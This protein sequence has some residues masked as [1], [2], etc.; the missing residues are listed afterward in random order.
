MSRSSSTPHPQP[1][2]RGF[3]HRTP[4][5]RVPR[6][7]PLVQAIGV[8]LATGAVL[9]NA[10]AQQA[11]S[12]A[13]FAGKGAAQGVAAATGRLP[14]G[15]PASSL[16][17]PVAQQQKAQAELQRSLDNLNLAARGIAA[18]QA[19]QAAARQAALG[20]ASG[21]PDGLGE[22]GL[23][24]DG[25]SLTAGWANANAPVQSVANGRT[26]VAIQQTADKA[27][28]NW[29]TFNV[30]RN[31]TVQFQ[32]DAAWAVLNRVNDPQARPS[33]IQGQI[34]ADGT[35]M[36]VNRNG[37]V[38][39]GSS[40]VDSRNLVAAAAGMS[41]SQFRKGLYG[42]TVGGKVL[43]SFAN[44]LVSSATGFSHGKASGDVIVE[45]GASIQ[46]RP[47]TTV[48][49]GGGY[50]LLAGRETRNGGQI[51]TPGG[52]TVL[53]AG[54]AFA[55]SRGLDSSGN[56]NSSTR[57]NVVTPLL[58]AGSDAGRVANTG[59]IQAT[60]GDITLTGRE[61]LQAGVIQ[62]TSSVTTRGTVH[63]MAQSGNGSGTVT[64]A[65]GS[66]T[67]IGLD[68]SADTA[69][70]AQR[71]ALIALS[72]KLADGIADRR[73]LSLVR[74]AS[75]GEV[76]FQDR[77]L[78]LA[79]GGQVFVDA[80]R[81]STVGA[82][83]SIDVSGAVGVQL[84]MA[85]NNVLVNVQGNEQR[86][87]PGNRDSAL[88][89]NGNIWIDRRR[90]VKVAKGTGGYDADRWYTAGGLLEVGGYLGTSGHGIGEWAA[91]GGTVQFGGGELLTQRG[92]S[93][94]LSGGTLD[95]ATGYLQQTFLKGSDGR[96]Y[97]ASSAP[98]DLLYT[99]IYKGYEAAHARWGASATESFYNP[100]IAPQRRLESGYTV[101][102]DAGRLIVSTGR[103]VLEGGIETVAFQGERQQSARDAGLDSYQQS[104]NAVASRGQ[105]VIGRVTPI[106]DK[107][108]LALRE[109]VL[110]TV[111][112]IVIGSFAAVADALSSDDVLP[113]PVTGGIGIDAGWLR[114][115]QLGGLQ[116]YANGSI[117]VDGAVSVAN[118]G[119]ISLHATQVD[120]HATLSARGGSISLGNIVS[121]PLP[122]GLSWADAPLL[123][124][125]PS[126]YTAGVTLASGA[127]LDARGL[128]SNLSLDPT[129]ISGLP[130]VDGGKVSLASTGG[131]SLAAG[132]GINVS[133]GAA[134]LANGRL[135]GGKGGDVSLASAQIGGAGALTLDGELRGE[136][137]TGGGTLKVEAGTAVVIGQAA[138]GF[139]SL[140]A[141]TASQI[142]LRLAAD[143]TIAGG[144]TVPIDIA[145]TATVLEGG[146]TLAATVRP[147]LS[148][149]APVTTLIDWI[150]PSTVVTQANVYIS[151]GQ[152]IPA[153][154]VLVLID[155]LS[156]GYV[157]PRGLFANGLPIPAVTWR[158]AAGSVAGGDIRVPAGYL[159]PA[160]TVWP[161]AVAT[162]PLLQLDPALFRSGF[163]QYTVTGQD[164]LYVADGTQVQASMPLLQVDSARARQTATGAD[165]RAAMDVWLPPQFQEDAV[166]GSMAVRKGASVALNAG[167]VYTTGELR[168]GTGAL[169]GVDNGATIALQGNR[170]ITI[171]GSL[172]AHG[173]AVSVLPGPAGDGSVTVLAD[174]MPDARSVWV[175]GQALIDVSGQSASALDVAGQRYGTVGQGGRI[176]IGNRYSADASAAA[177]AI[178]AFIVLRPG[179]RL[180]AS[181]ASATLDLP[182]QGAVAVAGD[183]GLISLASQRGLFLDGGMRALAGGAGASAG[184][185]ALAL[186][187]PNY[188]P[189]DLYVLTGTKV[190][191]AVRL[192]RELVVS[193]TQG[194]GT[195][196]TG[197]K[198]GQADAGLVYGSG[199]IGTDRI[200]AGGF[201]NLT[202]LVNGLLS[203]DGNVDLKLA[204]SLR[205]TAS[206]FGLASGAPADSQVRLSAPYVRVAGSS[207]RQAQNTFMPNPVFGSYN[208]GRGQG[209]LG[210]P[211]VA[212]GSALLVDA[213][214]LDL[215]GE[216]QSGA[217]G[218]LVRNGAT[219]LVVQRDAFDEVVLRSS[220]DMR[221]NDGTA[222]Y[223]SGNLSL[224]AA[225]VYPVTG[226]TA[227]LYAGLFNYPDP[228][229]GYAS[230]GFDPARSITVSR[231]G[232]AL[233]AVPYSAFGKLTLAA[234]TV[235]Q[236]GVL[237]APLGTI[238]LGT[239]NTGTTTDVHLLPGSISSVSAAGLVMPY[240]GTSDGLSYTY[241]GSDVT[242]YGVGYEPS[243]VLTGQHID[244]QAGATVDL[245]GGGTLTGAG[246]LGG[247]GGSVDARLAPLMQ[248]SA[249]GGGFVLPGLAS[250]PVYAIVPGVQAGYAPIS[251]ENGAGAPALGR[252]ITIGA[253][254]PGLPAGTYTLLPSTYA[255]LPGAFRVEINGLAASAAPGAATAMRNGSWSASA[256]LG[257]ANTGV[258]QTTPTQV[259]LTSADTLRH[260]AQYNEMAYADFA[261]AQAQLDGV[262][263][264]VLERDVGTLSLQFRGAPNTGGP[265][266][267]APALAFAA[268]LLNKPAEA[269][270]TGTVQLGSA[271]NYEILADGAAPTAGFDGVS[272]SAGALD[273]MGAS[274]LLIGGAMASSFSDRF[275]SHQGAGVITVSSNTNAIYLRSGAV[276]KAG[277]IVLVT[278][279]KAGEI[280]VEQGASLNTL[281]GGAAPFDSSEG[282]I[283][284]PGNN[285]LLAVSNGRLDVL[286]PTVPTYDDG[287]GAGAIRIGQC[288]TASCTA[289]TRLTRLYSEGSITAATDKDFVLGDSVRYGTRSLVLAVGGINVGSA[290]SLA[291]AAARGALPSGLTLNQEVLDRLLL[292]DTSQGAPALENLALT[293]RD[294]V[295]FYG[296]TTLSTYNPVSGKSALQQL[297][298][299]TPAIYGW[300]SASDVATIRTDKL[301]WSG[302]VTPPGN[303]A[304]GGAGTG[305]GRL[306]IDARQIEFGF[307]PVSRI[308][309][310]HSQDRLA[311]GFGT[312]A[313]NASES[314][315]ANHQGSLAVYQSRGAWN[316]DTKAY[317]YS[318]GQ[319]AI[320]T[321]LLTGAA[322]S[323]N[324]IVAGGALTVSAPAGAAAAAA[325]NAALL[326]AL[327]AE[328]SLE[329]ASLLLDSAVLLPSGKLSLSAG[330]DLNLSGRAQI[331]L[332]GRK[333]DFFDSSKYSWGGDLV[334][335]SR[336]GD[337][338]QAA[339]SVID[340]SAV[341]NR[342]GALGATALGEGAGTVDL[343]G[344]LRGTASGHY[345]AGGT[346]V[347][348]ESGSA[349]VRAQHIADFA[350]LN[351][352]L[353]T[354]GLHGTRS[355]QLKQGDLVIGDEIQ[356]HAV[357]VSVDR[358]SLTVN[359]RIDASGERVGSIRLAAS[360]GLTVAGGAL[361]DAHGTVLRLDSY[362]LP[363]E[364][365]NRAAIELD[366]GEGRL[367][368]ASGARF[369]LRAGTASN[370]AV[371]YGGIE[372]N[373]PRLGGATGSDVDI[374]AAG[375]IAIQ[376]ARTVNL[377][378]FARYTDAR[379]GTDTSTDG[380]PYQVVDQAYLDQK[381]A[382]STAF[383]DH[384]LANGALMDGKL[385]GL[386]GY[387][388]QFHLRPGVIVASATPD[389]D[390]HLDG[391]I[392]LS[393][394]RYASI[395]PGSPRTGMRGSGEAGALVLRAGGNLDIFGSLS[396][397]FDIAALPVTPDDRG[398]MLLAGHNPWGGDVVIPHGGMATLASGTN[399][400]SGRTLNFDLP[401]QAAT[402]ATGT[403]LP[404]PATLGA[405]LL[406]R[407]GTVLG[408]DVFDGAGQKVQSAGSVLARDFTVP[409][410]YRLGAGFRLA[411]AAS[412]AAMT[413]PGGVPLP[414]Q[415]SADAGITLAGDLS[416]A[417]GAIVP[418]ETDVKLPGGVLSVNLRTSDADGNQ[419][420][421]YAV[422]GMLPA[423]SRSWDLR[424]VAG[425]D[426]GAADTRRTVPDSKALIRMSDAHVG[427]GQVTRDVPGTGAPA[428]YVW[429]ENIDVQT[430]ANDFGFVNAQPG[431][432]I[433]GDDLA[434]LE[435]YGGLD[436]NGFGYGT[437]VVQTAAPTP[438]DT[439]TVTVPARQQ[440][441]SV[442]RT[443]TGRLDLVSG[444]D[445]LMTSLYGVYT[446]GTPSASL[447][448]A[449]SAD[450]YNLPRATAADGTVLGAAGAAYA[451]LV[452][453]GA[454]SLYQAWY[455]E[456]GGDLLV[457]AGGAVKGDLIG[458]RAS[459]DRGDPLGNTRPGISGSAAVGNWLWRQGTGSVTPGA[460]G[461]PTAW[462]INFG[463]YVSGLSST[464]TLFEDQPYLVG[465]TGIGTLGGGN[466]VLRTGGDAGTIDARGQFNQ[467]Y[468]QRSQGL[469]LAVGSTGRIGA[470]GKPVLTGGGDLDIR[471][472]GALNPVADVRSFQTGIDNPSATRT[473]TLLDLNGSFVNL[474][475]AL[476]LQTGAAGGIDLRYDANDP[477]ESRGY[478]AFRPT[479][480]YSGGG[481]VLVPGDA[482]VRVDT[483]G[484]LVVGA[485][486]DPGRVPLYN[487]GTPFNY[488]GSAF[489]GQ[490]W[491]WF[492]LWTPSTAVDLL[493]AGG[494][495]NPVSATAD[496]RT[497]VDFMA[498]D[499]RIVYPSVLR[500]AAASGSLFYGN[501]GSVATPVTTAST[502]SLVL[503]PAPSGAQFTQGAGTGQLELLAAGSIFASGY[504]V[505]MSGVDPVRLPTPF[506]PGFSGGYL[507]AWFGLAHASNVAADGLL[508]SVALY[509]GKGQYTEQ[510]YPLFSL[511][512]P[513]STDY[514][515]AGQEPARFY[516]VQGD[517]VGLRTGSIITRA[518]VN[519]SYPLWYE[520]SGTVA[521][522]A[523]RDIVNAGTPLAT[524]EGL[525]TLAQGYKAFYSTL[526]SNA[527]SP[528]QLSYVD[529]G[530]AR[531]NL[532]VQ[533]HADDVSVVQAGRDI[534]YSSFYVAGPGQLELTAGR[535]IY[536]GDKAELRSIGAIAPGAAASRSAGAGIAVLAG[537]GSAGPD[538]AG[539][540][541]RYL[542]P[543]NR[544]TAGLALAGQPGKVVEVYGGS[545]SLAQWLAAEFGYAG[546]EAGAPAFLAA[547]QAELDSA[548]RQAASGSTVAARR[549]LQNEYGQ[550]SQLYLV[551]WLG[552]RF[553]GANG[554]GLHFD[555]ATMDA[556]SFF[557]ALPAEQ[558][559]VFLRNVYYAELKASGREYNAVA[560][561][562]EGSYLRGRDAIAALFPGQDTQGRALDYQGGLTMF[563]SATYHSQSV[564]GLLSKRPQ[565]GKTY[566]RYDDWVAAGSPGYNVP[567]YEVQDAGIHTDFGGDIQV[568]TPGGRTLVGVDGGFVPASG[569]GLLTQGEGNI[570]IYALG[571]ILLG[572]S[573][574]FTTFGGNIMGWSATGDINAGRGAKTNVV[575]TPQLRTYDSAGNV[576]LSPSAPTTGAGIAT[577]NPIPEIPPGDIDL[578]APLGTIDA[579]EAGI[580]VSGN[581]NLAAL[582]VANA[583]NIQVQGKAVGIPTIAAVNVGALSN[584]SAA[585]AQ[586]GM[587]AQET[588]QRERGAARQNLPSVFTVRVLDRGGEGE[589]SRAP[590]ATTPGRPQ[591][592]NP[593]GV[594]Q[595]L[596]AG[597]LDAAE[598]QALTASERRALT[599]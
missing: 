318:G 337:I 492:S 222:V 433:T 261:I 504:A 411:S 44:E 188:Q 352:R 11:F 36:V 105:L 233:P 268:S 240:G 39:S 403:L 550:T 507:N 38:F 400:R 551:N 417:K 61:V 446:A 237:R 67:A 324:R 484:D 584:A 14:N 299:S 401:M 371:A 238:S 343:A 418:S 109:T 247:R 393:G 289:V 305:S 529:I 311:L 386:R 63:L 358:G 174:G 176:E 500:A 414:Y 221:M 80:A 351:Q 373:A 451:P 457:K 431:Q 220:G 207:G 522:R 177:S 341:Q 273:A 463:S 545:L 57:G 459:G 440:L 146:Q 460:D 201:G 96:L 121:R 322:G 214:L 396:D 276:L 404:A 362:G 280:V 595:V 147:A 102:R 303:V 231:V 186:E 195:L 442:I 287:S 143:Y 456:H 33:Q 566:L 597:R 76:D 2:L 123:A 42:D 593:D 41:D 114:E 295:N 331:D 93:I 100:L 172:V 402:L 74:I 582:Q 555:A 405:D 367:T 372:L 27:I 58:A 365:A 277:E 84:A 580:R 21:V 429:D 30:G 193:A 310:V 474:R 113:S 378:A 387:T 267:G 178:D 169:V 73:D 1:V 475:G 128:W 229:Y 586:A 26:T 163:S 167:S 544:A 434:L 588:L 415:F 250:N 412:I 505:S 326:G 13:W 547:R 54:D 526:P 598:Q 390:L 291:D 319:L 410:G 78:T 496:T 523:G 435:A 139:G 204:E 578:V 138:A 541:A 382:D 558:Q 52:Q 46:T 419:G 12:R 28:L 82:G 15:M 585:A 472:G 150:A 130:F 99:G 48:T 329:G 126:G 447:A 263:R 75:D 517:I 181:G 575:Y 217:N 424:L 307:G 136:G 88:L 89:N 546:D 347:P 467:Y 266:S 568:M 380:R 92:S 50:V 313:L 583:A 32:Q 104:Q 264:P 255:L 18:Q 94:N 348:Y 427:L 112:R 165:P 198:A 508:P 223:L 479:A 166:K 455:P 524:V 314:V 340:L 215:A 301:Y 151:P 533:H 294:A 235:N 65:P 242:L 4:H 6:L 228:L 239:Q 591:A 270:R 350:G 281:G 184:T 489:T 37:I 536:M 528:G 542:D 308:D 569:S 534:R 426:L 90:L 409:A 581:V 570:E 399:F 157:L 253:G 548:R 127:L 381:H 556:R 245:S 197:L 336:G 117:L 106:Y 562:R 122:S 236:G 241:N 43:P 60:T 535:D 383:I 85:A 224:A 360:G 323:V 567:Y 256:R 278:G 452:D 552:Q 577:L 502:A 149:A 312:V 47:A 208:T 51:S 234:A 156:A 219:P 450:R 110:P 227:V 539:F 573:R 175:G 344:T 129:D 445:I 286:A 17:N 428:Q 519:T 292:G 377:N 543:A 145:I 590:A 22:G 173:G 118:G 9:G 91:Q 395:H 205:I 444:G 115:Q 98:G 514:A 183:G 216:W 161:K 180:E 478:G 192:P 564:D 148:A 77:S 520:G 509:D 211:A 288:A 79:T 103:A 35:V 473:Q 599:R 421:N 397:G 334:M 466:L 164:G 461:I 306:E 346:L 363:I 111:G 345:D 249:Q 55:I 512:A 23:K 332:A 246:F 293:A 592:Y 141:G 259:L 257:T 265:D 354:G 218:E 59:L 213:A 190:D 394:Y 436:V 392:D 62:S 398:W 309:A 498:T 465:F 315:S 269:G 359:G 513:T 356:A 506:N 530:S 361:L 144:Q 521:I 53:A 501:T 416:L 125:T 516:A 160:G 430:L 283:Y 353:N 338:R 260:Y 408:G 159:L 7:R 330:G 131:V 495:L 300:G 355:F 525:P 196:A 282:F 379:P 321:P 155:S 366:S 107:D 483:R 232:D 494:N 594:V 531:G 486:V 497:K 574:V 471:I 477:K 389:G 441:F 199:R 251:A 462:W 124:V 134:L 540:A 132:S 375:T 209:K 425:A 285:S 71:A 480:A 537:V 320:A 187:A 458:S 406:L 317:D 225:Q 422:A 384:A 171:E 368:L 275:G 560:G 87:A 374:D 179:A 488:A 154:T 19:A 553:G 554:L 69:L 572:Q 212:A 423:G 210:A 449:G 49:Q 5:R 86:D 559:R 304:S 120:V 272:V 34:K 576:T 443:G 135:R 561:P 20:A 152:R 510:A 271:N 518:N 439:E 464:Y 493:S 596:G 549:D 407:A 64:L 24:V 579:G 116:A 142:P 191:N 370:N 168:I 499:G 108:S 470:D 3:P 153:G 200:A 16:G 284:A 243:V 8:M 140:T 357:E 563:S 432:P 296:S 262:P 349:E 95:V 490:G 369:D 468:N 448:A 279:R 437:I 316:A 158:Y 101:G 298:L 189:L 162:L 491:T 97:E 81:R 325:S 244:L 230:F 170:Q 438:P 481:V 248:R 571:S 527:G 70:D 258:R 557:A 469:D 476:Q 420:R 485:V 203:F 252:Q 532:I 133:S 385:A 589:G 297:V 339:G 290:Q 511:V 388:D 119:E 31:T 342:A 538:Y 29:E 185:L 413:W 503:A 206:A 45:P 182:G 453:G 194:A 274:R 137:V 487:D 328:L 335:A 25:N 515:A 587:A 202:L 226:A 482:G 40:Q 333:I 364:A 68:S 10:Q 66:I 454:G 391:D 376:G 302:A 83:A 56:T 565:P 72:D 327:G 254:V